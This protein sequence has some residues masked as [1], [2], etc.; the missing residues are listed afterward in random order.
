MREVCL[1][2]TAQER[3]AA[4]HLR[5]AALRKRR[6]RRKTVALGAGCAGLTVC[7]A[8]LIFGRSHAGGTAGAYTGAAMLFEDAG[9]YVLSAVLAFMLGVI[10]TVLCFRIRT[11]RESGRDDEEKERKPQ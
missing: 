6:E 11:K 10:I 3:V 7:L 1:H 2:M 8:A 4:L 5:M 9:G